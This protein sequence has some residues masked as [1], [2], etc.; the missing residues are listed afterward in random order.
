MIEPTASLPQGVVNQKSEAR[1]TMLAGMNLTRFLFVS[2]FVV[3]LAACQAFQPKPQA[4]L[5]SATSNAAA[6]S[7]LV[8][9]FD[10]HA[11]VVKSATAHWQ[12]AI[13]QTDKPGWLTWSVQL[14][15]RRPLKLLLAMHIE[16]AVDGSLTLTPFRSND[17]AAATEKNFDPAH[18]N[19]LPACS[20][21]GRQDAGVLTMAADRARCA[22]LA[23]ALGELAGLLPM[24]VVASGSAMQV[25]SYS[26]QALAADYRSD[27]KRVRWFGGWAAINGAGPQA[28]ADSRDWHMHRD[29]RIGSEGG[30]VDVDFRDG[31]ASGYSLLLETLVV[32]D[33]ELPLLKLS[34]VDSAGQVIAYAWSDPDAQRIGINLGWIQV[35]LQAHQR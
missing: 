4:T 9:D 14:D 2:T 5:A 13:R 24:N 7:L 30:R 23:A 20:L 33:G 19:E 15:S 8:G 1:Q 21:R 16:R 32:Q 22:T 28:K 11:Q 17:P 12:Y 35:G 29:L 6:S 18:W 34:I 27:A 25:R 3:L 31:Q 26:D 10:N